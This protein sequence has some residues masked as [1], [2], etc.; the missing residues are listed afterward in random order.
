MLEKF[1]SNMKDFVRN[2][3]VREPK[4]TSFAQLL[5]ALKIVENFQT[6]TKRAEQH[7]RELLQQAADRCGVWTTS[8]VD[9]A[10]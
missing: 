7:S 6:T 3:F 10:D 5:K 4:T 1:Q 9:D 8:A 2:Y